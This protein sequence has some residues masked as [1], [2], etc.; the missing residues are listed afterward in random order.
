[1][2]L[3][4]PAISNDIR[5]KNS[6]Q[7]AKCTKQV[8]EKQHYYQVNGLLTLPVIETILA[9]ERYHSLCSFIQVY[10]IGPAVARKLYDVHGLQTIEHL[11]RFYDVDAIELDYNKPKVEAPPDLSIAQ[12]LS[13]MDDLN[14]K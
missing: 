11:R 12:A 14:E 13:L 10:G 7:L 2:V 3:N 4:S 6:S 9:S 8:S 1:M 5:S